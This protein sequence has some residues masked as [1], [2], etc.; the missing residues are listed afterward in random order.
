[1]ISYSDFGKVDIRVGR[2]IAVS[3]FFEAK[4]PSVVLTIDFGSE[5]GLKSSSAQITNYSK[6]ALIGKQILGVVNLPPKKVGSF[7]SEVLVL[8]V[9]DGLRKV[10]LIRPDKEV[11]LG[12]TLF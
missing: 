6:D 10:V 2:I 4:K 8:G 11:P 9:L 7:V 12:E 3:D 5:M 1:M